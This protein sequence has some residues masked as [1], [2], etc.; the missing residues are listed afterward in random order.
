MPPEAT[1]YEPSLSDAMAF[2]D[3]SAG[4]SPMGSTWQPSIK[5]VEDFPYTTRYVSELL[6]LD[7]SAL[8][9]YADALPL[10]Q[11]REP[12]TG[13][14]VFTQSDINK[15]RQAMEQSSLGTSSAGSFTGM[16][17]PHQPT[18]DISEMANPPMTPVLK[19]VPEVASNADAAAMDAALMTHRSAEQPSSSLATSS[20]NNLTRRAAESLA[21]AAASSENLAVIIETMSQAKESILHDLSSMLDEKLAGLDEVVVELIRCKSEID[22]LK[23][24]VKHLTEEKQS[25]EGELGRYRPVQFGF[26]RKL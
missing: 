26:F 24:K 9:R 13:R 2:G 21:P 3:A 23:N 14:R 4:S 10:T 11:K 6:G 22:Q 20:A 25:L 15:I 5:S 17:T 7:E 18:F 12:R 1:L 19:A 8:E 16:S